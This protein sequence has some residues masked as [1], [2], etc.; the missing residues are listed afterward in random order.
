MGQ[1]LRKTTTNVELI[2]SL[3]DDRLKLFLSA[4]KIAEGSVT[5]EDLMSAIK[6]WTREDLIHEG[7][8]DDI[9]RC[10]N[11]GEEVKDRRIAKGKEPERGADGK[12]L[13]LVK[14]M[15]GEP[16]V[17]EGA[18]GEDALRDIHLFDNVRAGQIVGRVYDPKPGI[19]G[20]DA[21]GKA[22]P[23]PS[24][25]PAQFKLGKGLVAADNQEGATRYTALKA[26]LDGLIMEESGTFVVKEELAIREEL[27]FRYGHIDFI[28]KVIVG[29]D[30]MPGFNITAQ[31]GIEVRG[32]VRGGSLISPQGDIIVHG[33]VYG[34]KDSRVISGK[35]FS[36]SVV[37]QI[38]AEIQGD[39]IIKKEALDSVLRTQTTL[40]MENANLIGGEAF[41]VCGAEVKNIGNKS[42]KVTTIYLCSDVEASKEFT[43]LLMNIEAHDKA[44]E[45]LKLHL[46]PLVANPN[47]IPHLKPP[48]RDK[49]AVLHKKLRDL[50]DSKIHLLGKKKSFSEKGKMNTVP[51]LN[52]RSH[53]YAGTVVKAGE[54]VYEEKTDTEG[55]K[56]LDFLVEQQKFELGELKGLQCD[57]QIANA[58]DTAGKQKK[59]DK[60]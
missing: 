19:E 29:G 39:I 31:K 18:K 10:L 54:Q 55:P 28:G 27:D 23:A 12:V 6:E 45:L 17:R 16:E 15:S 46:G 2:G 25:N 47:N 38:N 5:R 7:V 4:K 33:F 32:T 41:V 52:F 1:E 50:E 20:V 3:T 8:V 48:F 34:G 24:G 58:A 14:K 21:T 35:S 60:K 44:I 37:Q 49:M 30:V 43:S 57:S 36:A 26:E 13:F 42:G 11:Q 9:A 51:R 53:M 22:L 56:S 59:P 40:M